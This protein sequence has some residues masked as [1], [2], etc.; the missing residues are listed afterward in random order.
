MPTGSRDAAASA[1]SVP[2]SP[3]RRRRAPALREPVD[4][5][6]QLLQRRHPERLGARL[7]RER[8]EG[9][10]GEAW[11]VSRVHRFHGGV[12]IGSTCAPSS[13]LSRLRPAAMSP[14]WARRARLAP[15]SYLRPVGSWLTWARPCWCTPTRATASCCA[16][17]S[18]AAS[19]GP[20]AAGITARSSGRPRSARGRAARTA[21][22]R[23]AGV[24]VAQEERH[25]RGRLRRA[26]SP[27][28]IEPAHAAASG[29]ASSRLEQVGAS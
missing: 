13:R 15:N 12:K 11:P 20:S 22:R 18:R 7:A 23:P 25:R 26:R 3:G 6:R 10:V 8:P 29:H 19:S 2:S 14:R 17:A 28:R 9:E 5:D 16:R 21:A 4:A 1:S 27:E 24:V